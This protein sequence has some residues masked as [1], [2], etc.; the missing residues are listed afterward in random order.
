[1][2]WGHIAKG[3]HEKHFEVVNSNSPFIFYSSFSSWFAL[4]IA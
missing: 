2:G 1:M 3:N 4:M